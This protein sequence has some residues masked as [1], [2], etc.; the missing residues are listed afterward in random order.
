[1]A[2]VSSLTVV[3]HDVVK[4]KKK[5]KKKKI[6]AALRRSTITTRNDP[7]ELPHAAMVSSFAERIMM[8]MMDFQS[9]DFLSC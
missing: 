5:K 9:N 3:D 1:M 2:I 8:T 6:A 4:K 7:Y